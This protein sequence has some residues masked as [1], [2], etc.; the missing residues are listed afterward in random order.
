MTEL[1]SVWSCIVEQITG[2]HEKHKQIGNIRVC[3]T[4]I[5]QLINFVWMKRSHTLYFNLSLLYY[6]EVLLNI[7]LNLA[8]E[9]NSSTIILSIIIVLLLTVILVL[10]VMTLVILVITNS[11]TMQMNY[12][13]E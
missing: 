5:L 1:F 3:C 12:I 11:V 6:C 10:L 8:L 2:F 7:A 13:L 9:N 4:V